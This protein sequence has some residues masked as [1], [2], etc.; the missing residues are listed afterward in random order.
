MTSPK[1]LP[2]APRF[3][4]TKCPKSNSGQHRFAGFPFSKTQR[5][6]FCG[7]RREEAKDGNNG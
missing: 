6:V 3:L 2:Q 4:A 5:C 7:R 1:Q